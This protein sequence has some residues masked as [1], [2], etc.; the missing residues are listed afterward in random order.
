MACAK[1]FQSLDCV[2][3]GSSSERFPFRKC[4]WF[5]QNFVTCIRPILE[6]AS[7]V[8]HYSLPNQSIYEVF[9]GLICFHRLFVLHKQTNKANVRYNCSSKIIYNQFCIISDPQDNHVANITDSGLI[10]LLSPFLKQVHC[11][12]VLI[13]ISLI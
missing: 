5:C 12:F 4:T 7:I 8:F 11:L 13:I 9:G 1:M 6:Y 2:F 3:I 10:S